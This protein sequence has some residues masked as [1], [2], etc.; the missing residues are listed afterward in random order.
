MNDVISITFVC[1][2]LKLAVRA[3][4]WKERR[5][6]STMDEVDVDSILHEVALSLPSV[7]VP[8][9]LQPLYRLFYLVRICIHP[10]SAVCLC[11]VAGYALRR[12]SCHWKHLSVNLWL[13]LHVYKHR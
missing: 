2:E 10:R 11:E 12:I 13:C 1:G 7:Q 8:Q 9:S 6:D 5:T 3:R 4:R